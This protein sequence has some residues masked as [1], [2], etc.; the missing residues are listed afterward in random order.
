MH[1]YSTLTCFT[2]PR[3]NEL[4]HVWQVEI[5]KV[6]LAYQ[7]ALHG[8][9][10]VAAFHLAYLHPMKRSPYLVIGS[11]HQSN[12]ARGLRYDLLNL[13]TKNS[14]ACFAASTLLLI[15]AFAAL[16]IKH[17]EEDGVHPTLEEMVDIFVLTRGMN[18]VL[19]SSKPLVENGILGSFLKSHTFTTPM[20]YLEAICGKLHELS[21]QLMAVDKNRTAVLVVDCEIHTLISCIKESIN[22]APMPELRVVTTWPIFFSDDF[23]ALLIQRDQMAL[24]VLGYYCAVV[25][26]SGRDNWYT[27]GWG[28]HIGRDLEKYLLTP[29]KE[30]V[31]WPLNCMSTRPE[32]SVVR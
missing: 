25:H 4:I 13:T 30:A 15:C 12:T 5:V 29:W 31:Q 27:N 11:Q 20:V 24:T 9:L 32:T 10:A 16:A 1:H 3:G 18:A 23:L 21:L 22:T 14:E 6:A 19:Q 8:I 7:P 28:S 17:A 2:L 26:E